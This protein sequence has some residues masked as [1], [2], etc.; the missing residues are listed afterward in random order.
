[1]PFTG[2]GARADVGRHKREGLAPGLADAQRIG[3]CG[4]VAG[5]E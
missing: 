5:A 1:M 2:A 3:G 4:D